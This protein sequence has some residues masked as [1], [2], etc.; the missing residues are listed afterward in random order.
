M[1]EMHYCIPPLLRLR[2]WDIA[3]Y[4]RMRAPIL[5]AFLAKDHTLLQDLADIFPDEFLPGCAVR[6]K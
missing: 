4:R 1:G 5:A 2:R 3:G 6:R